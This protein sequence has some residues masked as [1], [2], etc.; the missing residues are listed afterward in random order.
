MR[1]L[2]AHIAASIAGWRLHVVPAVAVAGLALAVAMVGLFGTLGQAVRERRQELAIR[3]AIGASPARIVR[4]VMRGSLVMTA[5]GLTLGLGAAAAAGRGLAGL[6]YGVSPYDP[7]TFVSVATL[8]VAASL[9]ASVIPARR[10]ARLDPIAG[11][12]P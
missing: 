9:V 6:L 11:L 2:D 1:T 7:V 12:G 10:A 8:V 5:I 4:L 3:A